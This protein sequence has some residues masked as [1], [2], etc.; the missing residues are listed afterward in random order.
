MAFLHFE[1]LGSTSKAYRQKGAL[2][3]PDG[4]N[5]GVK[6]KNPKLQELRMAG[7]GGCTPEIRFFQKIGFLVGL[8]KPE[9]V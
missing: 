1:F 8:P 7:R 6:R 3:Y 2:S 9:R 5:Q 4:V